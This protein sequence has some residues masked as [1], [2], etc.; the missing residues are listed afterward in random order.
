MTPSAKSGSSSAAISSASKVALYGVYFDFNKAD[1]KPESHPTLEQMARFLKDTPE[2]ELLV[3][4]TVPKLSVTGVAGAAALLMLIA[5]LV[6][7]LA[8]TNLANLLLVRGLAR[9][10]GEDIAIAVT[11]ADTDP[12]VSPFTMYFSVR[13]PMM[14]SPAHCSQSAR[15]YRVMTRPRSRQR[16]GGETADCGDKSCIKG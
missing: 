14:S 8:C 15:R 13:R 5:G 7:V 10:R 2:L 1:I 16:L 12:A 9:V 11:G 4:E 3:D 6:L